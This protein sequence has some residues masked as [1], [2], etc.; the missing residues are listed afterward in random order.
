[1]TMRI[2]V[3]RLPPMY[4]QH[5]PFEAS[6]AHPVYSRGQHGIDAHIFR[7]PKARPHRRRDAHDTLPPM[8]ET[9]RIRE[10]YARRAGR[11]LDERY[12]LDAPAN[13]YL[14]ERREQDLVALLRRHALLPPGERDIIDVGCGNGALLRDFVRLGADPARCTGTDLLPD[15]IEAARELEPRMTLTSGDAS[16]LPYA[17]A[18]FDIALQFTLLSSVLDGSMRRAIASETLRVLRPGGVLVWYDFLW[19]PGNRDVRG[20][21]LG[22]LRALYPGCEIDACRV[23]LAPPLTRRLARISPALC[24]ALEALPPLRS[25]YLAALRKAR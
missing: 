19:N 16:A 25:H 9:D 12:S 23:T 10:A 8:R 24:R 18:S 5:L 2:S 1:M 21:H 17:D 4:I 14:F 6:V 3:R 7:I 11:G 13:R 15:R 22:E 20:I